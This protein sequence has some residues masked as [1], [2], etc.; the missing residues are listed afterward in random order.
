MN[1]N[2]KTIRINKF[3]AQAGFGSRRGV[4]E[5]VTSHKVRIKRSDKGFVLAKLADRVDS[6]VDI[7]EVDGK[8]INSKEELVYYALN[9]PVGY[10]SSVRESCAEKLVVDLVPKKPK[11]YPVGRLDKNSRGLLILTNDGEFTNLLTHPKYQHKKEYEV[12]ISSKGENIKSNIGRL[13]KGVKLKEGTARLDELEIV[14][15]NENKGIARLRIVLHQ[16]WNR[17]IRRMCALV[18]L[19]VMDLKRTRIEK[20]SIDDIPEGNYKLIYKEDVI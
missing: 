7:V 1:N 17:Q 6:S 15:I 9:K 8:V 20:L 3:L 12:K 4:E 5:L 18:G 19:E 13:K 2:D 11:V 14:D 10:T 16:G